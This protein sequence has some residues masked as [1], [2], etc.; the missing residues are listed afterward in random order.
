MEYKFEIIPDEQTPKVLQPIIGEDDIKE[1][2]ELFLEFLEFAKTQKNAVGLA[3]NQCS[4]NGKRFNHRIFAIRD[5]KEG[6]W[7]LIIDPIVLEYVGMKES[8][9]EGCLTWCGRL[10]LADRFRAVKVGYYDIDG[11]LHRDEIYGGFDAQIWQHEYNHIEGVP[12]EVVSPDYKLPAPPKIGRNDLCPCGSG[13]KYK[14]CC[15]KYESIY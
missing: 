15:L 3:A 5:V 10:I 4:L 14:Q 12:E 1:N 13:K 6:T 7:R 8:K 11:N 2:R 9:L